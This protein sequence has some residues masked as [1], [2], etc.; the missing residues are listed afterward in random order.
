MCIDKLLCIG[1]SSSGLYIDLPSGKI[2]NQVP[3]S[4]NI[5]GNFIYAKEIQI[6]FRQ[7]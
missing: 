2:L 4:A 5:A 1:K 6:M 7:G 3:F